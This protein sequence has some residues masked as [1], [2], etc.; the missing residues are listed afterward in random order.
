[1][2]KLFS[3][4]FLIIL[5]GQMIKIILFGTSIDYTVISNKVQVGFSV[6]GAAFILTLIT[7]FLKKKGIIS[8]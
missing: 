8:Y 2:F 1:M 7:S 4:Y 3:Y 5:S 6:L